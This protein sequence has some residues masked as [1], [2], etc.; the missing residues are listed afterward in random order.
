M[1]QERLEENV[2]IDVVINVAEVNSS[3]GESLSILQVLRDQLH[4][5]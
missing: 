3:I 4:L 1:M 2:G 5:F